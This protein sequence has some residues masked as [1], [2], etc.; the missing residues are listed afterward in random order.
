[1]VTWFVI[2]KN[3]EF[4]EFLY[5]VLMITNPSVKICPS[6]VAL[7]TISKQAEL[8]FVIFIVLTGLLHVRTSLQNRFYLVILY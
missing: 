2:I 1:M 3:G 6:N 8:V 4:V 7:N 5:L